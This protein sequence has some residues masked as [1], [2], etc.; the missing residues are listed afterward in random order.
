M[1]QTRSA[2]LQ[3]PRDRLTI[4]HRYRDPHQG[5]SIFEIVL[6]VILFAACWF[7]AWLSLQWSYWLTLIVCVPAAGLLVRLFMIQHDCGHGTLFRRR[8]VN[9]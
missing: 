5:R 1:S 2:L 8:R 7:S 4:L 6:T 9:D 3:E